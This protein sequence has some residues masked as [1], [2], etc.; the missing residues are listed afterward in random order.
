MARVLARGRRS[1][2]SASFCKRYDRVLAKLLLRRLSKNPIASRYVRLSCFS[3]MRLS[4]CQCRFLRFCPACIFRICV[5]TH[6]CVHMG[7]QGRAHARKTY[8]HG[9][10][11]TPRAPPLVPRAAP[12][13]P[14]SSQE[15]PQRLQEHPKSIPRAPSEIQEQPKDTPFQLRQ[16]ELKPWPQ[17]G[18]R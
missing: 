1:P 12:E 7:V 14:R 13:V 6:F 17:D 2:F 10:A 15:D 8:A 16:S 9:R 4:L 18:T 3:I 5:Y 11:N